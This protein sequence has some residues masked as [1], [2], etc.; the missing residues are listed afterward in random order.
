MEWIINSTADLPVL[1][2]AIFQAADGKDKWMLDGDMGA[3]KTTFTK[4]VGQYLG[5]KDEVQSPTFGLVHEYA[6]T[7]P[8][9]HLDLYRL[10]DLQEAL[11]LGVEDLL[12]DEQLTLIEWPRLILPLLDPARTLWIKWEHLGGDQRKI[13]IIVDRA[14]SE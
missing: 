2:Q 1:V 13:S 9:R 12:E 14:A 10:K 7:T 8:F 4:A 6:G 11:D 3:G 5:I